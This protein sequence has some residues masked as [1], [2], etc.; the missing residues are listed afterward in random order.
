LIL[1]RAAAR[2]PRPLAPAHKGAGECIQSPFY[3][4]PFSA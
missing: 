3:G 2:K 4:Y 1:W